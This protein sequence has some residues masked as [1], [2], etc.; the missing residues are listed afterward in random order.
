MLIGYRNHPNLFCWTTPHP[1]SPPSSLGS[2]RPSL[3]IHTPTEPAYLIAAKI[4]AR[5]PRGS[6]CVDHLNLY[7]SLP[8]LHNPPPPLLP[9]Y[10]TAIYL[11]F[12]HDLSAKTPSQ[13]FVERESANLPTFEV[14]LVVTDTPRSVLT[15]PQ[16]HKKAPRS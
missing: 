15:S 12:L 5:L 2:Q 9:S 13:K 6:P 14:N 1:A 11:C 7:F 4:I 10:A 16:Q 8:H 3:H